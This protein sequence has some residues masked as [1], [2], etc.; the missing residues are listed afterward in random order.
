MDVREAID[1][2]SINAA[3]GP[4]GI[5]AI[6]LKKRKESLSIPLTILWQASLKSGEIPDIFKLAFVTPIHKTG[7]S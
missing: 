2:L 6:L 1:K 5:P 7:S 4:D 3:P